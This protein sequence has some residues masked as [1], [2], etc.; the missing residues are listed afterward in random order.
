M[1]VF[2]VLLALLTTCAAWA[3]DPSLRVSQYHKQYW[4]VEQGLPHSYVTALVQNADGYLLVGTDE[5]LARF[6]GI[7][8]KPLP[9]NPSLRLSRR[10][11]SAAL[12]ARDSSLWLGTFDGLVVELRDGQVHS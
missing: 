7:D 3:L 9:S 5:G 1:P 12:M 11:I 8:F 6:D 10:W 2:V 4:Q